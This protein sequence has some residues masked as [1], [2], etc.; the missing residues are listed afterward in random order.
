MVHRWATVELN[1]LSNNSFILTALEKLQGRFFRGYFSPRRPHLE[2]IRKQT[3]R[4][5]TVEGCVAWIWRRLGSGFA[6]AGLVPA[7]E[8]WFKP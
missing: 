4:F 6:T 1:C 5:G 7:I 3:L 2:H 8:R